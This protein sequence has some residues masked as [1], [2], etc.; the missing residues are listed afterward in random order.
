MK[1]RGPV[2]LRDSQKVPLV[3]PPGHQSIRPVGSSLLHIHSAEK[4]W[5]FT[6]DF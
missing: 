3:T 6:A 2:A 4:Y 5:K 1:V